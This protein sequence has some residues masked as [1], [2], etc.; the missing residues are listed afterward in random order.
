MGL[1]SVVLKVRYQ[2]QNLF[3]ALLETNELSKNSGTF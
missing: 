3:R 1:C 2:A